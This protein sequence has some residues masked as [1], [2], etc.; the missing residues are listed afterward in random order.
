MLKWI[1]QASYATSATTRLFQPQHYL[2]HSLKKKKK[3]EYKFDRL[4]R[5]DSAVFI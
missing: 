3:L 5:D 4:D 2:V 1:P